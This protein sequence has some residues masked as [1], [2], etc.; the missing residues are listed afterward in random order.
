M[1]SASRKISG[2]GPTGDTRAGTGLDLAFHE[3]RSL[4][5]CQRSPGLVCL[6]FE[7][8]VISLVGFGPLVHP[9]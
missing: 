4:R 5:K 9:A 3:Q 7:A 8:L 6:P 2:G 1:R